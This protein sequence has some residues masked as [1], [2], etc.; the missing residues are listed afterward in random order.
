LNS[1]VF[2]FLLDLN[3]KNILN[4]QSAILW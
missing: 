2:P 1:K 4:N 3:L